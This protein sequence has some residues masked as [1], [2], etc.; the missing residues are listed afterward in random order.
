M[1][2]HCS[3]LIEPFPGIIEIVQELNDDGVITGCLSN[4][5]APHWHE[6]A[7]SGRFPAVLAMRIRLASH[8]IDAAKPDPRAF[9]AFAAASRCESSEIV[10]FDDSQANCDSA[11]QLGW[12]TFR[13]GHESDPAS[14]IRDHLATLGL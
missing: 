8:E 9:H 10:L 13:I 4:T 14:Q 7:E 5:N 1:R 3:M 2:V 11:A 12:T 6:L